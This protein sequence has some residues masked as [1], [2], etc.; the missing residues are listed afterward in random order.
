MEYW[1]VG[2]LKKAKARISISI[3]PLHYSIT[4]LLHYSTTPLL[5]YSSR[6]PKDRTARFYYIRGEKESLLESTLTPGTL[7]GR[8]HYLFYDVSLSC[9]NQLNRAEKV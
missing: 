2:V 1:S 5:H 7:F 8:Q 6:L 4:P 9:I 3:S